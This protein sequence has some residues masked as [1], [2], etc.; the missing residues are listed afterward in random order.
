MDITSF[1]LDGQCLVSVILVA[2]FECCCHPRLQPRLVDEALLLLLNVSLVLFVCH[3]LFCVAD[4]AAAVVELEVYVQ[5]ELPL[6]VLL[7]VVPFSPVLVVSF[8][9]VSLASLLEIVLPVVVVAVLVAAVAAV[10]LVS[11]QFVVASVQQVA[12]Q[13]KHF[14]AAASV[15][16]LAS[17]YMSNISS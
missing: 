3:R 17:V 14:S 6:K 7:A 4:A 11:V 8:P 5:Y 15:A 16:A 2:L 9:H 12:E 10:A 13:K 1:D